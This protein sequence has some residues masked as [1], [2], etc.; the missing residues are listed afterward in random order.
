MALITCPECTNSVSDLAEACPKCGY[1]LLKT[2]HATIEVYSDGE[3]GLVGARYLKEM[4]AN[5]WAVVDTDE[6]TDRDSVDVTRY[7]LQKRSRTT[8]P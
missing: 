7:K 1:P 6:F 2:E 5:G 3:G 8:H 4:K